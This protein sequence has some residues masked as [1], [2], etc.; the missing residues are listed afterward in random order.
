MEKLDNLIRG[1]DDP[2][3]VHLLTF[4]P[5][6]YRPPHPRQKLLTA[7]IPRITFS[8]PTVPILIHGYGSV[9]VLN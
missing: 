4:C 7:L 9:V 1:C 3:T 5:F 2:G 8:I 6:Y